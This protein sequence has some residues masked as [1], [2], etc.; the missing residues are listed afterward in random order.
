MQGDVFGLNRVYEQQVRN[1]ENRNFASWPEGGLYGY[2]GGGTT[3]SVNFSTIDRLDFSTETVTTPGPK[4]SASKDGI[5]ATSSSSYGYFGGGGTIDG[6]PTVVCTID[7]LDFSTE[8]VTTP[9]PNL[10]QARFSLAATS[11]S[12][13][14]YFAGGYG[15]S[16]P[17]R[18]TI[19]RL[20]FST[21]TS[22]SPGPLK[23]SQVIGMASLAAVSSSSY[24][25]FAGG[26]TPF[27]L[28][29]VC[30]IDRL[31]FS[32]ETI[33]TP[34]PKLSQARGGLAAVSS[35]SYGYFG[36]GYAAT[37]PPTKV[38]TID[39][40]DFSTE[41]VTTPG[42]QLSWRRKSLAAVSNSN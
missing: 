37:P 8:T 18:S 1:V 17:A 13:Y 29:V 33:S 26:Y 21:E 30:T 40:L 2:F 10:S 25:Y 6:T 20:D 41:T 12:S 34:T 4:L 15:P 35:S 32:T 42:P 3:S 31:D 39:R 38:C 5:A 11:S 24:G 7:R 28:S 9:T 23:L 22:T 27:T 16:A 36:G 19:D 14:G